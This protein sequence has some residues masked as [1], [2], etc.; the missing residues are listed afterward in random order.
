MD[1]GP[2]SIVFW[3]S[4]EQQD[5]ITRITINS[6]RESLL[7]ILLVDVILKENDDETGGQCP[8]VDAIA[9]G[10]QALADQHIL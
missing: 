9:R 10:I 1:H 3:M 8:A 6:Q 2:T 5:E 4:T 7:A